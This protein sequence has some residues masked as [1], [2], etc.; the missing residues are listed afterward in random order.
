[1]SENRHKVNK[2][3]I[4]REQAEINNLHHIICEVQDIL[5]IEAGEINEDGTVAIG[6]PEGTPCADTPLSDTPTYATKDHDF[7]IPFPETE[8]DP[9]FQVDPPFGGPFIE[10]LVDS[11]VGALYICPQF[12]RDLYGLYGESTIPGTVYGAKEQDELDKFLKE[13]VTK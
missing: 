3:Y 7:P 10:S 1:M 11:Y 2:E 12:A 8:I 6:F 5:E 4:A 13:H 9:E